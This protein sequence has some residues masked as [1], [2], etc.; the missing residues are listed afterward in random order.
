[1]GRLRC[2]DNSTVSRRAMDQPANVMGLVKIDA[3]EADT[4]TTFNA[5][6]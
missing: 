6:A 3:I 2:A 5:R 1:M 4:A